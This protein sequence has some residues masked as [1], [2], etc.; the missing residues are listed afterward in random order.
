MKDRWIKT[1]SVVGHTR[2]TEASGNGNPTYTITFEATTN[3]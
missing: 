3:E 1:M 2:P